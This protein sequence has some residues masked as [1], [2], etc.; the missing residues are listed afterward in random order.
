MRRWILQ[1]NRRSA[2]FHRRQLSPAP[3]SFLQGS[4]LICL[5]FH[6]DLPASPPLAAAVVF[7]PLLS[8]RLLF[9]LPC[10]LHND[11]TTT[12]R[13]SRTAPSPFTPK[14]RF[15]FLP[16]LTYDFLFQTHILMF[17]IADLDRSVANYLYFYFLDFI[18]FFISN[19]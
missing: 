14:D 16:I 1:R 18:R 10:S 9:P 12:V 7:S 8:Y 15:S 13:Q 2:P 6:P 19:F 3:P 4:A 11:P 5:S 17:K